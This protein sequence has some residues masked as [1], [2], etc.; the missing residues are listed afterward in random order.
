MSTRKLTALSVFTVIALTIYIVESAIPQ[1]VPIPGIKLGLANIVT[2][3]LLLNFSPSDTFLVLLARILLSALFAG[4]AMVLLYSLCG[5]ILCFAAMYL[6]NRFLSGH[7]I[8]ITS[9]F[10]ALFHNAGQLLVAYFITHTIGLLAY[11]PFLILSGIVTGLFTGLCAHY[12]QKYLSPHIK[13]LFP[14][15]DL[16]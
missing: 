16:P 14:P 3:I 4:Q 8:F 1:L 11:L 9:I 5:G 7:F 2:L 12:T 6:C 13:K 10:G 15:K